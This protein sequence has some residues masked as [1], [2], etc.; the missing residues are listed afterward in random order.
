MYVGHHLIKCLL[1]LSVFWPCAGT[2]CFLCKSCRN[3][4]LST[5]GVTS[6]EPF[7]NMALSRCQLV[8]H[9]PVFV[10][11]FVYCLY[12]AGHQSCVSL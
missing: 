4:C 1:F 2:A 11:Y 5:G 8:S 10:H 7:R 9:I 3:D 12:V 6:L